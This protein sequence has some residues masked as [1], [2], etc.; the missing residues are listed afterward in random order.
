MINDGVFINNFKLFVDSTWSPLAT[1]S[2]V[3][4]QKRKSCDVILTFK[5]SD[6]TDLL[7][8]LVDFVLKI[9]VEHPPEEFDCDCCNMY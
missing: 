9:L 8:I 4:I 7:K 6:F 5:V 2:S 1:G 3:Y